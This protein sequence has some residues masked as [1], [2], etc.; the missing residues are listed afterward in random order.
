[1]EQREPRSQVVP[2][3]VIGRA[4][5]AAALVFLAKAILLAFWVTPLWDVPDETGHYAIVS[6]VAEGRGLPVQGKSVVSSEVVSDWTRGKSQE[7]VGNWVAQHPPLYH[8]LAA[9][10]YSVARAVTPNPRWRYRAPRL[11]SAIAG[12][13]GLLFFFLA[14]REASGDPLLSFVAA[15]GVGFVPMYSH[16]ASGTNH[17]ILLAMA[18]GLTALCWVRFERT[19][20]ICDAMKMSG[21]LA[22]AGA[23]KLSAVAL[24]A[25]LW[26]LCL[27]RLSARGGRRLAQATAIGAASLSLPLLWTLRHWWLFG[28][29]RVHPV[30]Q[31]PFD[32]ASFFAYLR[33]QPVVDHTFKNFFGLIG[34]TGTGGGDLK[35]FQISGVFL[36]PYLLLALAGAAGTAVW[37]W[38]RSRG[39]GRGLAG[40]AA[41]IVFGVCFFRLFARADGAEIL[42]RLVYSLLA[43]VPVLALPLAFRRRPAGEAILTGSQFVFLIFSLAYLANSFEAFEIYGQMRATNGRYFFAVLPFLLLA[44]VFPAASLLPKGRRRDIGLLALLAALFV[45]ETAFFVLKVVPF[46]RGVS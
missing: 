15:A 11:L 1:M 26:L 37:L 43:A 25:A 4:M 8:L 2:D 32:L 42:K 39:T 3:R 23:V 31:K 6:D 10:F 46:Y 28:N 5:A 21:A 14:F 35:W 16:L 36:A 22:F 29:T 20:H 33:D 18:S 41:A 17:D 27:P 34:W 7:P 12:A 30:S 44:F 19:G 9:P 38:Q 24:A 40:A 13:A 45:N